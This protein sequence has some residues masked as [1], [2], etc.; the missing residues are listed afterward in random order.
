MTGLQLYLLL[1]P[2]ALVAVAGGAVWWV[3]RHT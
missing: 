1:A 2:L 3:V